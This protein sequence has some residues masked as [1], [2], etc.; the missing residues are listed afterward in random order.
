MISIIIDLMY[1]IVAMPA[2]RMASTY[3]FYREES[4]FESTVF[5]ESFLGIVRAGW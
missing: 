5:I 4:S 1:R 2:P 3:S